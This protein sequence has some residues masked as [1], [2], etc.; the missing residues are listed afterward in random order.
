MARLRQ[1]I[2]QLG[3]TLL[4]NH[5]VSQREQENQARQLAASREARQNSLTDKLSEGA[6]NNPENA[7]QLFEVAKQMGITLPEAVRPSNDDLLKK[8][9]AGIS[10]TTSDTDITNSL[11]TLG[12]G[13]GDTEGI[14][15]P[16]MGEGPSN[17]NPTIQDLMKLR[18]DRTAT[19]DAE[20]QRELGITGDKAQA[21]AFG[22]G[23]GT[24]QAKHTNAPT[25]I[26]DL[27]AQ[28]QATGPVDATNA[29]LTV[30]AQEDARNTP[31]RQTARVAEDS[32]KAGETAKAQFPWQMKLAQTRADM[33]IANQR[34]FDDYKKAHPG[35]TAE[36]L[37]QARNA[38]SG[39][40]IAGDVRAMLDEMDKRGMIGAIAGRG[41]ELAEGKL[42]SEQLF[43][44][45][46]DAKLAADYFSTVSLLQKLAAKVHGGVR[47]GA[48][49]EMAKQFATIISG[50]GDRS[51]IEGQLGAVER[52]LKHYADNP[53]N[54]AT[55][56]I[57]GGT[58]P[59]AG[60]PANSKLDELRRRMQQ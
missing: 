25:E 24:A 39:L 56:E 53:E 37:N 40:A 59:T 47:A 49:P 23:M 27:I 29:G 51:I 34:A 42:K 17:T 3:Q 38:G 52:I 15:P 7:D 41:V 11:K 4:Q 28:K 8:T 1:R 9:R 36:Q 43:R 60:N 31:E 22:T 30:G 12:R 45:P 54:P 16:E 21:T 48:S 19:R 14:L 46:D 35:A 20:V 32:L 33:Q 5:L 58:T 44:N 26:A 2:G 55:L 6:I 10:P 13:L 57:P 18:A 50:V